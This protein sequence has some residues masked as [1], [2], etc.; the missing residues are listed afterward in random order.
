MTI[1]T[2]S[3]GIHGTN[4]PWSIGRQA[5]HGCI[6]LYEDEMRRL[7]D[8]TPSG[9]P[10]RIVYQPYKWGRD[11]NEILLEAHPDAYSRIAR[12]LDEALVVPKELGLLGS[13][14]LVRVTEVLVEARGRPEP[15]GRRP[16]ATSGPT[17]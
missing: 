7:F 2:T 4:N 11:G 6:R 16:E 17:W 9:T 5:T 13:L 10:L 12:P 8:R 3:Y 15:V 1:G 14:D